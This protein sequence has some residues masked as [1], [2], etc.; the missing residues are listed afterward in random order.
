MSLNQSLKYRVSGKPG[1]NPSS[2]PLKEAKGF[3]LFSGTWR[4]L[5][6]LYSLLSQGR[7]APSLPDGRQQKQLHKQF[8]S[9]LLSGDF[10]LDPSLTLT[11]D[12]SP[13]RSEC[14][15]SPYSELSP[16]VQLPLFTQISFFC[17]LFTHRKCLGFFNKQKPHKQTKIQTKTTKNQKENK[18]KQPKKTN[19]KTLN[20]KKHFCYWN[21]N[22][23]SLLGRKYN[24]ENFCYHWKSS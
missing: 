15:M 4:L 24:L 19:L 7:E 23:I 14:L 2:L 17:I 21:L 13:H 6:H 1:V 10:N 20:S 8:K 16:S 5:W 3:C 12:I 18:K 9:R 11:P 22:K